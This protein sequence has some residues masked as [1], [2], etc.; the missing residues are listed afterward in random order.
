MQENNNHQSFRQPTI[1]EAIF[2]LHFSIADDKWENTLLDS[3]SNKLKTNYPEQQERQM[4]GIRAEIDEN[5]VVSQ[6]LESTPRKILKHSSRNH[7]LQFSPNLLIIN[8]LPPYSGWNVFLEDISMAL[9]ILITTCTPNFINRLGLRYINRIPRKSINERFGD[10]L[11]PNDYYP[12]RLQ[13]VDS[14]FLSRFETK[15]T[16]SQRSI[17]TVAEGTTNDTEVSPFIFDIDVIHEEQLKMDKDI[18]LNVVNE[19]HIKVW[20][21]FSSSMTPGLKAFLN[22]QGH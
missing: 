5:G 9:D 2:E 14:K 4:K 21:I 22:M 8:Q 15:E 16:N 13:N 7:L 18:I 3:F 11:A 6:Q 17:V 19:Q 1:A 20:N 10:W 12:N